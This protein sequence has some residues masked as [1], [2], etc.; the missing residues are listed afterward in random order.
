MDQPIL[1]K[2]LKE[3]KKNFFLKTYKNKW[4]KFPPTSCMCFERK[5]LNQAL[6]KI[7]LKKFHNLAVDFRLAV[8]FSVILK[9]F[10]ILNSHYT[11]YRQVDG[12]MD[13]KYKK[14]TSKLWWERRKEAFEFLNYFLKKN[15]L[16]INNNLDFYITNFLNKI[17]II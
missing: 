10:Y 2:G 8:Y 1:K 12:G 6:K 16:P 14:Y 7:D 9:K 4:P 3:I 15:K 13:S 5:L 11:Y 17:L